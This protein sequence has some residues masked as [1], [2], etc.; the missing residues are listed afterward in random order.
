MYSNEYY[1]LEKRE[2]ICKKELKDMKDERKDLERDP[3]KNAGR[4]LTLKYRE[5][6]KEDEL[7]QI[8]SDKEKLEP[9]QW[10]DAETKR[11]IG[12]V[13]AAAN[14]VISGGQDLQD[15]H[16]YTTQPYQSNQQETVVKNQS[17]ESEKAPITK[18]EID[19]KSMEF[20]EEQRTDNPKETD[21]TKEDINSLLQEYKKDYNKEL[22]QSGS[23]E[24]AA[25]KATDKL[26]EKLENQKD[27]NQPSNEND[28]K[29]EKV[30]AL[31]KQQYGDKGKEAFEKIKEQE[32]QKEQERQK[33]QEKAQNQNKSR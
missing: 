29:N 1:D 30:A 32:K 18:Q 22:R 3:E 20:A 21:N 5:D 4:I 14:T 24:Q 9:K 11:K 27:P 13:L 23:Y 19:V 6:A 12:G 10:L 7:K 26:L 17:D 33:E 8:K 16:K 25:E 15:I 31:I 2:E 28:N